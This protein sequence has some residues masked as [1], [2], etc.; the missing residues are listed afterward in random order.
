MTESASRTSIARAGWYGRSSTDAERIASGPKRAPGRKLVA[1][2]NGTPTAAASTSA[3]SVTCGSRMN[4]RTPANR[5][6][7][8]ASTGLCLRPLTMPR[9]IARLGL[10]GSGR[11]TSGRCDVGS[12]C[13]DDRALEQLDDTEVGGTVGPGVVERGLHL[14]DAVEAAAVVAVVHGEGVGVARVE[15]DR[16]HLPAAAAEAR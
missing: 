13:R 9:S 5:G 4:V 10:R 1:V 7:A 16:V 14:G 6:Y 8:L 3:R 15:A 12:A 11:S 2:S